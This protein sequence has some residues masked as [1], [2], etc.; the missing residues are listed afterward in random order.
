MDFR[1][2]LSDDSLRNEFFNSIDEI[3]ASL[4]T[5]GDGLEGLEG[6][7]NL[8]AVGEAA[9]SMAAG[10]WDSADSGLE[11]I[12]RRFLRPVYLVQRGTFSRPAQQSPHSREITDRL[13]IARAKLD[14][15][16]AS[17]GRINLRNHRLDWVGTGWMVAPRI[18]VTNRHVAEE[19]G[20][21][22]DHGF[23]FKCNLGG[24]VSAAYIDWREEYAQPEESRFRVEEI[25]W[26]EPEDSVDVA[27]LLI[28]GNGEDGEVPPQVVSLMT[29]H[30]ISELNVGAWIGVIGYPGYDSR[31]DAGDQQRL[32]DGVYSCKRLAPG[33]VT[34]F[35]GDVLLHH[36]ATTLGGNSGS[37]VVDLASGKALALHYGGIEGDHNS[38]ILAPH[39]ARIAATHADGR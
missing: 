16:I 14:Q 23:A 33:Q 32:F 26:I 8:A 4:E 13:E 19:F 36:D 17:T 39:V 34:A 30:D 7:I 6:G 15:V 18:V 11:A 12:I 21:A 2:L 35:V 5:I 28:S 31:N 25:T 20:R 9:E 29:D 10:R 37:V 27:L 22:T 24:K 38:A 1:Q 3:A